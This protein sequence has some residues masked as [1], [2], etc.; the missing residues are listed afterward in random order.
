[1]GD[2]NT[3][4]KTD[5][6]GA[7]ISM[8]NSLKDQQKQTN[9]DFDALAAQMEAHLADTE[10]NH[11]QMQNPIVTTV[12]NFDVPCRPPQQQ[13]EPEL[14][15]PEL[16]VA[17]LRTLADG[18]YLK[19]TCANCRR[20]NNDRLR[21]QRGIVSWIAIWCRQSYYDSRWCKG[22]VSSISGRTLESCSR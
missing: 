12:L 17:V 5:E 14:D 19:K 6:N 7:T 20:Q 9:T 13:Q 3:D 18:S 10:Y 15:D 8:K 22:F 2:G 11:E 21:I 4:F 1:M 16:D